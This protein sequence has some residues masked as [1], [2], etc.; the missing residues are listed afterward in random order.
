M[1]NIIPYLVVETMK[2]LNSRLLGLVLS[3]ALTSQNV[4]IDL[5]KKVARNVTRVSSARTITYHLTANLPVL[6]SCNFISEAILC[7]KPGSLDHRS[8]FLTVSRHQCLHRVCN[9]RRSLYLYIIY[10]K[11][12]KDA[13]FDLPSRSMIASKTDGD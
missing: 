12:I 2:F 1:V 9:W 7:A 13:L 3:S 6:L 11:R 4:M 8:V 10:V 5:S